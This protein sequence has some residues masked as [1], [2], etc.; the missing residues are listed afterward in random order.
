[1][2]EHPRPRVLVV[3]DEPQM[4][5]IIAF[6]LG[7]ADL[8]VSVVPHAEAA[9]RF[10]GKHDVDLVVLD[11]MLPGISGNELCARI[12]AGSQVPIL[13]LSALSSAEERIAGLESGAD[14][15]LGKPFSPRELVLRARALLARSRASHTSGRLRAGPVEV[16]PSRPRAW[17]D[18]DA[19]PLTDRS[20]ALLRLLA[21]R[22][23]TTVS[24]RELLNAVWETS[25]PVGGRE[26]VKTAVYRLRRELGPEAGAL[27]HTH[28]GLGYALVVPGNPEPD[29]SLPHSEGDAR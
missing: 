4:A 5:E 29:V 9:W 12:R 3:E 19:V 14:D 20:A 13:I 18:G 1:M 25:S 11:V 10:I 21:S 16:D 8:E 17:I 24:F 15:Y 28:R 2:T 22:P 27:I 7:R 23:G 26:M 6:A